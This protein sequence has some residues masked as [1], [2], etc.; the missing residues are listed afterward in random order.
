MKKYLLLILLL[1]PFKVNA[2]DVVIGEFSYTPAFENPTKEKYYYHDDYFMKSSLKENNH[3]LTMSYNLAISTFEIN[4]TTYTKKLYNDIGFKN[5][6]AEGISDSTIGTIIAHKKIDK[7]DIVAVAIRGGQYKREWANNFVAGETGNIK[8]FNESSKIINTRI[9]EYI[10]NNKLKNVKIWV[11]GYSRGGAIANLTGVYIN[12]HL[13]EFKTKK[14][15]LYV[16]TFEAPASSTDKTKYNNIYNVKNVNDI[17][18][19]AYPK[20]WKLYNNGKIVLIGDT[21]EITLTSGVLIKKELEKVKIDEFLDDYFNWLSNNLSRETYYNE[22]EKPLT[23]LANIFFGKSETE[24]EKLFNFFANDFINSFILDFDFQNNYLNKESLDMMYSDNDLY[25]YLTDAIIEKLDK[26]R[27]NPN[28]QVLTDSEYETFKENLY[29]IIRTLA[30]IIYK[31]YLE[32]NSLYRLRTL[33]E[34]IEEIVVN[35]YPQTNIE[36]IHSMDSY[37]NKK[38]IIFDSIMLVIFISIF[39]KYNYKTLSK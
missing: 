8:G 2:L 21:K 24:R 16:Y 23:S 12:N 25:D 29:P 6:K 20:K 28:F 37:Y 22:L 4:N 39:I 18:T 7:Y 38:S 27:S 31:D 32:D 1:I 14:E 33:I 26:F 3:L 35:H 34:N 17:V 9:K 10:K 15:D 36:I 30:P 5:I 13:K 11:V 19:F